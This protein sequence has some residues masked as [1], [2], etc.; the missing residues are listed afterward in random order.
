MS[1]DYQEA[2]TAL[3]TILE[4]TQLLKANCQASEMTTITS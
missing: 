2:W 3:E 4:S 1:P